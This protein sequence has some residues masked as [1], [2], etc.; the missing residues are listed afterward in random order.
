M[1]ILQPREG[2]DV[3]GVAGG[4]T[5]QEHETRCPH[6]RTRELPPPIS[7]CSHQLRKVGTLSPTWG[8]WPLPLG[9][10]PHIWP[11]SAVQ[12]PHGA[13]KLPA[14]AARGWRSAGRGS[15]PHWGQWGGG[16]CLPSGARHGP[17]MCELD[18]CFRR[19]LTLVAKIFLRRGC[20][21]RRS[22]LGKL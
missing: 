4:Q 17:L 19:P 15:W 18:F 6:R 7:N 20:G 3:A 8:H 2:S 14:V 22:P 1:L 16:R 21:R 10:G 11:V 13:R 5:L 9:Q 12:R